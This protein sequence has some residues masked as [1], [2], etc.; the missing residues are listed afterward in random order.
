MDNDG[1]LLEAT[2]A[3]V[4]VLLKN[5]DFIVPPWDRIIFG[6]TAVKVMEYIQ[7]EIIP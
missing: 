3:T 5:G 1:Y 4:G 7:N 2:A 6:T